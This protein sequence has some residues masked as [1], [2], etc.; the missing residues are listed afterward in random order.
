[1][2]RAPSQSCFPR[3]EAKYKCRI[4]RWF[5]MEVDLTHQLVPPLI[6]RSLDLGL[7]YFVFPPGKNLV[8]LVR[9]Q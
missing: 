8:V 9:V 5:S 4:R 6:L 2:M 3:V 1:M 7:G